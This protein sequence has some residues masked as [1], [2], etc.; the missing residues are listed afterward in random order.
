MHRGVDLGIVGDAA[1]V[2]RAARDALAAMGP[3]RRGYRSPE[4]AERV[5]SSRYWK[6][7]PVERVEEPGYV[8]PAQLTNELDA[9]V[10]MERTVVV[11]GGNV[12]C[13]PGAHLRVPDD[14]GFVLPLSF[15]AIGMGLASAVG[16]AIARRDRM[17][18]LGV[19]DGSLLMA[20][21]ELETAARLGLG[22]LIVVYNDAAYGA[23]IHLFPDSTAEEQEIVRF[24]D[25]DIASVARGYGCDA[26]TVRSMD[27]IEPV[28]AWLESPRERPWW[29]TR[30]SLADPHGS[31]PLTTVPITSKRATEPSSYAETK[32]FPHEQHTSSPRTHADLIATP[33]RPRG[34]G[35]LGRSRPRCRV[36][37]RRRTRKR[38]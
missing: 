28:R 21:A 4:V 9:L 18:V 22:M 8:D 32:E 11:D 1:A 23:E 3:A 10:P 25:T 2:S 5:R 24:P 13:Y 7:Q 30:R 26:V 36:R 29:S 17:T 34:S 19:G 6:D 37:R 38:R 20:A 27:D 16:A 35:R 14:A 15:Q 12:N 31:W 33:S